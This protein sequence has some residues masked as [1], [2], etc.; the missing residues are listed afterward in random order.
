[1][2]DSKTENLMATP[3]LGNLERLARALETD[4]PAL[5]SRGER[6]REQQV[7]ELMK[8]RFIAELPPFAARLS[9]LQLRAIL[10][11]VHNLTLRRSP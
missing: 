5:L 10:A 7:E 3:T 8:D 4:I 11:Q 6:S 1:L 2:A 9:A